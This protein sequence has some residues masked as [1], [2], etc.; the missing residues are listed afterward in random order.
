M[1]CWFFYCITHHT[2]RKPRS[3]AKS[4]ACMCVPHRANPL[5]IKK[6]SCKVQKIEARIVCEPCGMESRSSLG[7][8]CR[9]TQI[10][11]ISS[12]YGMHRYENFATK[13]WK[14]KCWKEALFW[15][16]ILVGTLEW[17]GSCGCPLSPGARGFAHPEPIG[18]TP[19]V[20]FTYNRYL[21][22]TLW[23]LL[24]RKNNIAALWRT[25]TS[26]CLGKLSL[27]CWAFAWLNDCANGNETDVTFVQT[28]KTQSLY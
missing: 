28:R 12:I 25:G 1:F 15:K 7:P 14:T 8:S 4:C 18:I 21:L 3:G 22:M 13:L 23:L 11:L 19:L 27:R 6:R 9:G 10:I 20:C 2:K 26:S 17:R 5:L 24:N 16:V